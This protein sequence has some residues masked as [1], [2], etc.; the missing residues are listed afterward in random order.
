MYQSKFIIRTDRN[1]LK[2]EV[3]SQ[4]LR[5]TDLFSNLPSKE[6]DLIAS[7]CSIKKLKK[8]EIIFLENDYYAGFYCVAEGIVKVFK[9]DKEGKE[10]I[11]HIFQ[12]GNTFAEVPVFENIDKIYNGEAVF[13]ASAM[14]LANSTKVILIPAIEFHNIIRQNN[15]ICFSLLSN[16]SKRLKMLQS[17]LFNIKFQDVT[18]RLVNFLL[19]EF[20][21]KRE[22][23]KIYNRN[24][25]N[26]IQLGIS[27]IDLAA[28]IGATLETLSRTFKKLQDSGLIQVKGR[29]LTIIDYNGLKSILD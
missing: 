11:I 12:G 23:D 19:S 3:I 1:I 8:N 2:R 10:K 7:V 9:T 29:K 22:I 18:K 17:Q 4:S 24:A 20:D 28:Y 13:P 27:K 21:N 26:E 25:A 16:L 6:L 5:K 15:S 14:A